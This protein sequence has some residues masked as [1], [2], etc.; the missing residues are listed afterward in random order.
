MAHRNLVVLLAGLGI[1]AALSSYA[2]AFDGVQE[3]KGRRLLDNI[4]AK[5][6]QN[7]CSSLGNSTG[8]V[9][10]CK[11]C[12]IKSTKPSACKECY[13]A[14]NVAGSVELLSGC[15]ACTT[16]NKYGASC[17][18]CYKN[19]TE[20]AI[21]ACESCVKAAATEDVA[22]ACARNAVLCTALPQ[23]SLQDAC[24]ACSATKYGKNCE[25][26]TKLTDPGQAEQCLT[27]TASATNDDKAKSCTR[28]ATM[29]ANVTD[30][31]LQPLCGTCG[32]ATYG[33]KYC[34]ECLKLS[35]STAAATCLTCT[36]AATSDDG[37]K[38]CIRAA[39]MCAN[40][41]DPLLQPLCATCS[42]AP[43]AKYCPD[44]LK[45]TGTASSTC[46]TCVSASTNEDAAKTC[47]RTATMCG[48]LT[49]PL[50]QA[51]CAACGASKLSKYCAEC[52]SKATGA[53]LN[54]CFTCT[55]AA[56]TDDGARACLRTASICGRI[57]D[58]STLTACQSCTTSKFNKYCESCAKAPTPLKC[59]S[60]AAT[61]STDTA[62]KACLKL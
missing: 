2:S 32:Q 61:A 44:C 15:L 54:T 26:C 21:N 45:L 4:C 47:P 14:Y 41:T 57:T 51:A 12:M 55:A 25:P 35:N 52:S 16:S 19:L 3:V 42:K 37:A 48:A 60:C 5:D 23:G 38:N 59:Y 39:T 58:P 28:A 30:P 31:L 34:T 33:Y 49:A 53:A 40:T 43:F 13:A 22:K 1:F 6:C 62:A 56:T 24:E 20:D 50:D 9:D 18:S 8:T 46:L 29:C 11:T 7:A 10:M 27:C 17:P 36:A